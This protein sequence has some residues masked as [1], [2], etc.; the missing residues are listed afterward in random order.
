MTGESIHYLRPFHARHTH[1]LLLQSLNPHLLNHRIT[2]LPS[3]NSCTTLTMSST[4]PFTQPQ[5]DAV[6]HSLTRPP[7][8]HGQLPDLSPNHPHILPHA[9][10]K[11]LLNSLSILVETCHR[12]YARYAEMDSLNAQSLLQSLATAPPLTPPESSALATPV[13]D[14]DWRRIRNTI[15]E[16]VDYFQRLSESDTAT[17]WGKATAVVD[18]SA[19]EVFSYLWNYCS[20]ERVIDHDIY[21]KGRLRHEITLAPHSKLMLAAKVF[22][23]HFEDRVFTA[24]MVWHLSSSGEIV[25]AFGAPTNPSDIAAANAII[26]ASP[27]ASKAVRAATRGLWRLTPLSSAVSRI[28]LIQQG[29]VGGSIPLW[30]LNLRI[31]STL[32]F[33]AEIQGREQRNGREVDAEARAEF[34]VPPRLEQLDQV[35]A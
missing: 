20:Y 27:R 30:I 31:Q 16:P 7:K 29:F 15:Q 13:G 25:I 26:G 10:A 4:L 5:N 8:R 14:S 32:E 17:A 24:Y 19:A 6:P 34:P 22:P 21:E 1:Q 28:T 3:P 33:V 12:R 11:A 18:S 9:H 2:I 35:S 23:G